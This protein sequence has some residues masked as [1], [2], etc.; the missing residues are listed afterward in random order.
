VAGLVAV[1]CAPGVARAER[2]KAADAAPPAKTYPV[3]A[4]RGITYYEV[5]RDPDRYRH[6]L[7][8]YRPKGKDGC[9]VLFFVHGGGWVAGSKDDVLGLYGYGTIARCLAERGLVVVLPNYRL[10]PGVHHPEHI[11][12]VARAFAWACR[13]VHKYGGDP[14]QIFVGGHSAGGHLAALLAT[15]DTYLKQEGRSRK[16]I[17][18]VIAVSGVYRVDDL[19][20][21][22][23]AAD[24]CGCLSVNVRARP[25]AV[26]FGDDP[27]VA[28]QA[29]PL[30]HVRP[31]LPPFLVLSAG[32]DYPPLRRMAKEFT[33]AL[34][35]AGCEVVARVVPWR[36]HETLLFD[37]PRRSADRATTEA[38]LE[39]IDQHT[40]KP[41]GKARGKGGKAGPAD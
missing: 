25:L 14:G 15:D 23:S 21:E 32:L 27:K 5:W 13:N 24:S 7:D 12:D 6:Q 2:G 34:K 18:G 41:A 26:V 8:V 16:D 1:L 33:A 10:S 37:I 35:K 20:L 30:T 22:L 9:P 4:S 11:K 38:I 31:G 17:R 28:K 39:F 36:T 40:P 29:S 3:R 19:D